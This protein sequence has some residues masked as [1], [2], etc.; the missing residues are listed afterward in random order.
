[1]KIRILHI[2][3]YY[4][5]HVGGIEDI[6]KSIV[7]KLTDFDFE[8]LCFN[9]S[10]EDLID[11]VDGIKVTRA[12]IWK[13][14]ARQ[15]IPYHFGKMLTSV[16][17]S[18]QPDVIHLHLP[19]PL[20]LM[21]VLLYVPHDIKI[22][23]HWHSDIVVHNYIHIFIYPLERLILNRANTVIATSPQYIE[24]STLLKK[25]KDKCVVVPNVV[26]EL[27]MNTKPKSGITI[28]DIHH[29]YGENIVLFVG[30]HVRYK[31][32]DYLIESSKYVKGG[33]TIIIAGQGPDT[34][35]LKMLAQG[36]NNII[37]IG[38]IPD[39]ELGT[40]MRAAKVFAFPSITKNEAFGIVLAEAMYCGAVPVTFTID[41]SGVNWVNI[42]NVTGL[43]V[44]NK[45]YIEFASAIDS[46][47]ANLKMR[48]DYSYNAKKRITENFTICNITK[49]LI[50]IY[51]R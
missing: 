19:N 50:N 6:C 26:S 2:S 14:I 43:E 8:V 40:Y 32:I 24:G 10:K 18:F 30:R 22:V 41:G 45:N 13:Q 21:Y 15:S 44:A 12:G 51:P 39:D 16:L 36:L 25:Y 11:H 4:S 7:D 42:K 46:L 48:N 5:P 31:G 49:K 34:E 28:D 37:F 9:D 29:K 47:Q 23:V 3:K 20:V 38:R 27:K 35:H 1:M 17:K 33:E